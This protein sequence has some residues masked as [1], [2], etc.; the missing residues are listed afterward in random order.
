LA[1]GD[2]AAG[3]RIEEIGY[4]L[5]SAPGRGLSWKAEFQR[6]LA[7]SLYADQWVLQR[8]SRTTRASVTT[9]RFRGMRLVGE[10]TLRRI[11]S[12][13]A[14]EQTTR[15]GRLDLSGVW[16]RSATEWSLGYKVDNSR[17][18]VLDRQIVF[19][20][21]GQGN[22]DQDGNFVGEGQ[23][24]FN[25]VFAGTD[26]LVATTAV[27]AD[28]HWRQGFQ[29]L[30]ADRWYGA[31]SSLALASL[32]SR[33]TTDDVKGLLRLDPAVVFDRETTV[34]AD[35]TYTHEIT[36]LQHLRT[37]DLRGKFDFRQTRDRQFADSPEDRMR[38]NW[39]ATA[40]TNLS[41][42]STLRLRWL[43]NDERRYSEEDAVSARSSFVSLTRRYELGYTWN[44][45]TDLRFGLQGEVIDRRD[46]ISRVTQ[47]EYAVRPTVRGRFARVWTLQ[48]DVRVSDVTSDEPAGALRPYFY[49]FPGRNLESSLR[50]AWD[51]SEFLAVSA[52]W[53]TRK[54]EEGR[55]Q[56]DLRFETTARF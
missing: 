42:R 34:L 37:W 9:G 32:G 17:T 56:H 28:L 44:P 40:T 14:P 35:L 24:D 23:G 38:R 7:D 48:G 21:E 10:G 3:F 1:G 29:W 8:D 53:F 50:L 15:L 5:G 2:R 39:Q 27:Q 33:S 36:L 22:Y 20:G 51:P 46:E 13:S 45:S 54:K 49:A 4:G 18:E 31:W 43:R 26:S 16:A 12:P 11:E 55:W 30:G 25:L 19:V 52:T 6:G 41:A 47:D